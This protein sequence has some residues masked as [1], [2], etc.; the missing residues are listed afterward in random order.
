MQTITLD[1]QGF[2]TEEQH[3]PT[4]EGVY[5]VWAGIDQGS[6]VVL[7]RA[8]YIGESTNIWQRIS[9]HEKKAQWGKNLKTGETLIYSCTPSSIQRL[10]AEAAL[11]NYHKPPV[12]DE[13]KHSFP[14][15]DTL[16]SLKGKIGLLMENSIVRSTT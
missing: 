2:W 10:R 14:F 5:V 11:I 4:F 8:I 7:Y 3:L 12:N 16:I 1:F 6:T 13:Y 9:C 15:P